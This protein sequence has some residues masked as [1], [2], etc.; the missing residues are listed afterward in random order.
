MGRFIFVILS[1]LVV[2]FS[3]NGTGADHHCPLDWF[4]FEQFCYKL[5]KQ[6]ET[7]ADA[8]MFCV[9]QQNGSHLASIQSWAESTSVAKVISTNVLF[10]G[11]WI[12]LSDPEKK[13]T[14]EWSD[15][16]TLG[17]TSWE[18]REPNNVDD[19]YCVELS[20]RSRYRKWKVANC[21]SKH[22]FLCKL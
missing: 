12:G 15:G 20:K 13:R 3:L 2:A 8:E 6:W 7:W 16:S 10:S 4:S 14:W 22:F 5:I 21:E 11:V 17:H 1:L 9:Q 18:R 19:K